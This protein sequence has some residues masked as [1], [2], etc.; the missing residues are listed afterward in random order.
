MTARWTGD[1]DDDCVLVDGEWIAHVEKMDHRAWWCSLVGPD[2][3]AMNASDVTIGDECLWFSTGG[4][5]R[6]FCEF[7]IGW[8]K[9]RPDRRRVGR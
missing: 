3:F 1:L 9:A 4:D 2:G 8:E 7:L 5:A 6:R